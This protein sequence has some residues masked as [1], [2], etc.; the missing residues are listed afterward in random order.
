MSAQTV[1]AESKAVDSAGNWQ[2]RLGGKTVDQ[3]GNIVVDLT[4]EENNAA[5]QQVKNVSWAAH[6]LEKGSLP[7]VCTSSMALSTY[8]LLKQQ[9][10]DLAQLVD[11]AQQAQNAAEA[12]TRIADLEVNSVARIADIESKVAS[13]AEIGAAAQPV[14]AALERM[15]ASLAAQNTR[16]AALEARPQGGCCIVS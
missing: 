1:P 7:S 12:A 6:Q 15:E 14:L 3:D 5:R 11:P 10:D 13:A 8:V 16:L 4:S 9:I 2:T